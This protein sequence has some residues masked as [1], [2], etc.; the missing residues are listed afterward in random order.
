MLAT[1]GVP[2][3]ERMDGRVLPITESVGETAYPDL[4]AGERAATDDAAV[5]RR[6]SDLGYIE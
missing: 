2:A 6:L 4:D 5:E 1:L 3:G